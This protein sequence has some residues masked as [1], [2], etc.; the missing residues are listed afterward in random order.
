MHSQKKELESFGADDKELY[1]KF[2][3]HK[4]YYQSVD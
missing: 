4:E 1:E 2:T 3:K